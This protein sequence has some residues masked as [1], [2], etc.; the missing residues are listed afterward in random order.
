[1][2]AAKEGLRWELSVEKHLTVSGGEKWSFSAGNCA[3]LSS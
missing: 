2:G 3:D 1:M